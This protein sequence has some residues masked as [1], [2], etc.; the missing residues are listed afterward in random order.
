MVGVTESR[1]SRGLHKKMFIYLYFDKGIVKESLL[2]RCL[3]TDIIS[4]SRGVESKV[5]RYTR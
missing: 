3:T 1:N 4:N 2:N 5:L